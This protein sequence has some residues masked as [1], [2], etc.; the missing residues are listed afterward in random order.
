[1]R[2]DGGFQKVG[3]GCWSR[4]LVGHMASGPDGFLYWSEPL[5]FKAPGL[6]ARRP[7]P[8]GLRVIDLPDVC[9]FAISPQGDL[10]VYSSNGPLEVRRGEKIT[11]IP[12]SFWGASTFTP[13]GQLVVA[14]NG[15]LEVR[16]GPEWEAQQT[17][18]KVSH[19]SFL[20]AADLDRLVLRGE[21]QLAVL[22]LVDGSLLSSV[23]RFS[24][25]LALSP[26]RRELVGSVGFELFRWKVGEEP[27]ELNRPGI[28]P[29]ITCLDWVEGLVVSGDISGWIRFYC[30]RTLQLLGQWRSKSELREIC[31]FGGG[32]AAGESFDGLTGRLNFY[33]LRQ[34][35]QRPE[36]PSTAAKAWRP[37]QP[38]EPLL[39]EER[40]SPLAG[41]L[42]RTHWAEAVD[43]HTVLVTDRRSGRQRRL[44]LEH[45]ISDL[46]LSADGNL[47]RVLTQDQGKGQQ[48]YSFFWRGKR[49]EQGLGWPGV[50]WVSG[51]VLLDRGSRASLIQ[52]L[53]W[54]V[55][56][57][58]A[59]APAKRSGLEG[60]TWVDYAPAHL[61]AGVSGDGTKVGV[62]SGRR[63]NF[64]LWESDTGRRLCT[65][66]FE[67]WRRFELSCRGDWIVTEGSDQLEV[68]DAQNGELVARG[69]ALSWFRCSPVA[70]LVVG[71][72]NA[73]PYELEVRQLPGLEPVA[74]L[75]AN[76]WFWFNDEGDL[77]LV[78]KQ[79]YQIWSLSEL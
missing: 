23:P 35:P 67:S 72:G 44:E 22:S 55:V 39:L 37:R 31:F 27:K 79:R 29:G 48:R 10:A 3:S 2:M 32:V 52:V 12:G 65:L 5:N 41:G 59:P 46:T 38:R 9:H 34:V 58:W 75:P 50:G 54:S 14:N 20:A 42:S 40:S 70:N 15:K 1:M 69:P 11:R 62:L 18:G 16:Q 71:Q 61:S 73:P 25:A 13:Q 30:D 21:R 74:Q 64:T 60:E 57:S 51:R 6:R 43:P 4:Q 8:R 66:T 24:G 47:L 28:E 63:D 45:E 77:L 68:L 78:D 19:L 36:P 7:R 49:V 76:R 56:Q 53:G 26:D 33:S 17:L